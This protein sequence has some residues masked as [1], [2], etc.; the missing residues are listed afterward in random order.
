MK[1]T[2]AL[3]VSGLELLQQTP[4]LTTSSGGP[5]LG[6]SHRSAIPR[7]LSLSETSSPLA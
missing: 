3:W 7:H 6:K 4:V 1:C 5:A 2:G